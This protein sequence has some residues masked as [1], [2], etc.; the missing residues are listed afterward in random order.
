MSYNKF[1]AKIASD[2]N[3]PDGI[4]IVRPEQGAA[5]VAALPARRFYGVGPRTAEKMGRLGIHTGADLRNCELDFLR[6]HF[7]KSAD[8]LYRASRGEDHRPVKPDRVRK[9]IGAER[10]YGEDLQAEEALRPALEAI[11]TTVWER[12]EKHGSRGR[13]V[14]LKVKFNDFQQITRARSLETPVADRDTLAAIGQELLSGEL[15][16]PR[17]V[18]LLGLTVSSL[19]PKNTAANTTA[20]RIAEPAPQ[21]G[22]LPF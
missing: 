15:P 10:T 5:F 21:Q 6:Q 3:K 17:G 12:V 4:C 16:V 20:P 1:L 9:S 13:T 2:Q 8:Y 14:T 18:R 19:A 7:G 11:A 22:R